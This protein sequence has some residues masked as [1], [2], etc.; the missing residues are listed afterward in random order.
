MDSMDWSSS[1]ISVNRVGAG[2]HR[3]GSCNEERGQLQVENRTQSFFW[4][5]SFLIVRPKGFLQDFSVRNIEKC[6]I[7][8]ARI[9]L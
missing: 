4:S 5:T 7:L 2:Q 8:G 3:R 9:L 6:V 1:V